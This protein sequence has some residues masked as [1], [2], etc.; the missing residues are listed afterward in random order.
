M[1]DETDFLLFHYTY[2]HFRDASYVLYS[3]HHSHVEWGT[4]DPHPFLPY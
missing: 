4:R 1:E 3:R 2:H